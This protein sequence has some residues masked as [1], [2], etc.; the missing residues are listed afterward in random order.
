MILMI[1]DRIFYE[2]GVWVIGYILRL[3]Y[4]FLE[5]FEFFINIIIKMW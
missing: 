4:Y 5:E 2:G 1:M 3:F